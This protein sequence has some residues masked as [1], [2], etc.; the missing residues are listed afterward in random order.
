[1][2][3]LLQ[4]YLQHYYNLKNDHPS[5]R[6]RRSLPSFTSKVKDMQRFFGL[7]ATGSLD[8]ETLEVMRTPRC[9]VSDAEDY[10]HGSQVTRWTKNTLTYSV[11]KYT[12]DL[13]RNTVDYLI[14]SAVNI[15]A[16]ACS[17]TFVRSRTQAADIMM[18][19]SSYGHGDAF[20][21]DGAGGTLAHAF[22]PGDGTG[23][24]VHF[25]DSE[26]WTTGPKGINLLQVAVH[27]LGH[28]LGLRHSQNKE[29]VMY[30]S[31]KSSHSTQSLLSQEDI[32]GISSLYGTKSS[33]PNNSARRYLNLLYS[34]WLLGFP[35]TMQ[36][37][38]DPDLSFDAVATLGDATYFLK[39]KY[40]WIKQKN[41]SDVNEGPINHFWPKIESKID[42]AFWVPRE[43]TAYLIHG[44]MY[45]TV[46]GSIFKGKPKPISNFGIP[47]WVQEIDAAV[48]IA[49]TGRILFFIHDTY[50]SF[51][52]KRGVMD[53]RYPRNISDDF[54]GLNGTIDASVYKDGCYSNTS[55]KANA[56]L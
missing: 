33:V 9:G 47:E 19:F 43:S 35:L 13:P 10:S 29:S 40:L 14:E 4:E 6:N 53:A 51:N 25:D 17:L 23:G 3:F 18:E 20:P 37:K 49:K 55:L 26:T 56:T 12:N 44:S 31:Y 28:S 45:W 8:A 48:H 54:P 30:P 32:A 15:W 1:M 46:K 38:C 7:R 5:D 11:N 41:Q 50:Y 39:E 22:G 52:R 2:Y 24:D 36:N 34:Q 42:A 27:E 16:R 21:F